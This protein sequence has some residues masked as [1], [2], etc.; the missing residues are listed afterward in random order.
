M[1][2]F[3]LR[4]YFLFHVKVIASHHHKSDLNSA[5]SSVTGIT[6]LLLQYIHDADVLPGLTTFLASC[7]RLTNN[8]ITLFLTSLFEPYCDLFTNGLQFSK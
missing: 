1:C 5:V 3:S 6:I 8:K 7:S 4:C 2:Y